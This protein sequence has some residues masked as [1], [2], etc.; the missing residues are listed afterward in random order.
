MIGIGVVAG[1]LLLIY[2]AKSLDYEGGEKESKTIFKDKIKR[3]NTQRN[4]TKETLIPV[5]LINPDVEFW[6]TYF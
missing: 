1:A 4:E 3:K 5:L 2:F 6:S